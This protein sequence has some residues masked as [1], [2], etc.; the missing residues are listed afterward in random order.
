MDPDVRDQ[1]QNQGTEIAPAR[2]LKDD[3]LLK[4]CQSLYKVEMHRIRIRHRNGASGESIGVSRSALIDEVVRSIWQASLRADSPHN[5][6]PTG[7]VPSLAWIA[8]GQY[9]RQELGPF[10]VVELLILERPASKNNARSTIDAICEILQTVGFEAHLYVLGFKECLQRAQSD[11]PFCFSL[12]SARRIIGSQSVTEDLF[13]RFKLAQLKNPLVYIHE[14]EEFLKR[15]HEEHG[16]STYLLESALDLGRGGLLDLHALM[17]SFGLFLGTENVDRILASGIMSAAEWT[18]LARAR[19]DFMKTRDHLSWLAE[20]QDYFLSQERTTSVAEFFGYQDT[21]FRKAAEL[22]LQRILRGRRHI[23]MLLTRYLEQ[24]KARLTGKAEPFKTPYLRLS[25]AVSAKRDE[26]N[27][28]RWMKLFHFSQNQPIL[29]ADDLKTAIRSSLPKWDLKSFN[30][31]VMHDQFRAILRNKGKV[32]VVLRAMRELGF[33][34]KYL[35][36]F[37]R[38]DCLCQSDGVHKY[39]VDEHTLMAIDALDQIANSS[40]PTHHDLQRVLDQVVDPSLIY[41]ALLL[42]DTGKGSGSGHAFRSERL[43]T[44]TLQRMNL[45]EEGRDKV[46]LLVREHLLLGHVSQ[47]RDMDDPLIVQEVSDTVETAENLNMLLLL[48]Y[49]DLCSMGQSVWSERKQFLLWSLYFKVSD[50]LM[51]GDEISQPEHAQVAAIQQKVLELLGRE[52]DTDT[53]LKHFLFLPERYA[54][55]TPLPQILAHIRLC[56]RLQD[57]PVAT[58]WMPHPYA[59]YTELNLA[60]RDLPGRFAQIAGS[61]AANGLS[62]LSAQLNTRDDGIVIDTFQVSDSDGQAIIDAEDLGRVDRIL[63]EVISGERDLEGLLGASL[64]GRSVK[65]SSS[66]VTPRVRIDNDISA[67][68]TVIEV[69][70]EDRLGLGYH[71]ARTLADLGLNILSAKLATE[72]NHAFDVFYV[73]TEAGEKVTSSFQMTEIMERLRFRLNVA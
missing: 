17:E 14:L 30:T 66:V 54:L 33:L 8:L 2:T 50:R 10:S 65:Q 35:P 1:D 61:L 62:I 45:D 63:A 9:G 23:D 57:Y 56:E 11:F 32:A 20:R 55:Y 42:H 38:L 68:S 72:K 70:T 49:A 43:A 16:E 37:G 28:E 18:R 13:Q 19:Q 24:T 26:Q 48:T 69:Q 7:S 36:E 39:S 27:P 52:F 41:L 53:V 34:S 12:L 64:R 71:I 21:L 31:T 3:A 22:F 29:L 40:D 47:R 25:P 58:E 59:G 5:L 60:T 51:F 67:Q 73:Q 44:K 46:L 4:Y 15:A 6:P